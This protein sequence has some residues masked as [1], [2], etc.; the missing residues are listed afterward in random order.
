MNVVREI[1]NAHGSFISMILNMFCRSGTKNVIRKAGE[2]FKKTSWRLWLC[3]DLTLPMESHGTPLMAKRIWIKAVYVVFAAPE[4]LLLFFW[5]WG[6]GI[7]CWSYPWVLAQE[8]I[9]TGRL[10]LP[11]TNANNM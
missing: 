10:L 2:V 8:A 7:G 5:G 9:H 1:F 3:P 4:T 6:G 11:Q